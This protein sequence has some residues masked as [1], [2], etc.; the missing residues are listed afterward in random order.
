[1]DVFSNEERITMAFEQGTATGRGDLLVKW[2]N[3]LQTNGW[4]AD[5]DYAVDGQ[6]PSFG[7]IHR[8]GSK[9]GASPI[10]SDNQNYVNLYAGWAVADTDVD[11]G[12]MIN[13]IPMRGYVSGAPQNAI[14]VGTSIGTYTTIAGNTHIKTGFPTT[15]FENY[16]FFESD[17]YA[18]AVVEVS[19]GIFRHMGMGSLSKIGRWYGGEYYYGT[20]WDRGTSTIES[21]L[22]SI[23]SV[24]LD[25]QSSGAVHSAHLYGKQIDG[26]TAFPDLAGRQS[27][28]SAWHMLR[29]TPETG[30]GAG[31]DADGRDKGT[32]HGNTTRRGPHQSLVMNGYSKFNGYRPMFPIYLSA[33]YGGVTPDN[34]YPLGFQPDVRL[35]S[36]EG[37]LLPADEFTIGTDTWIA[38]PFVRRRDTKVLDNTEYSGFLGLAYKKVTT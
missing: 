28:E 20:Y 4:T 26:V 19:S 33:W 16:W 21:L 32:I 25:G 34:I 8:Q 10:D 36:M 2:F 12:A 3:F 30:L 9:S 7:V 31:A 18:H 23:H 29:N 11:D 27:P 22:T 6:S 1:L 5:V 17:F 14:E 13:I 38:F 15:P 37:N 24:A 35:I